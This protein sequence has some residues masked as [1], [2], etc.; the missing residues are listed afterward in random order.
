MLL[1]TGEWIDRDGDEDIACADY[2]ECLLRGKRPAPEA[3]EA[4][5]RHS[6]F[7]RRFGLS[8]YCHLPI[9]DLVLCAKADVFDFAMHASRDDRHLHLHTSSLNAN[10]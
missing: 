1:I 5:V 2:I 4:R 7:G 6:D 8:E 3:Y 10:F 9:D